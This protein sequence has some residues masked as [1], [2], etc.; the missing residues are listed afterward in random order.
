M[1]KILIVLSLFLVLSCAATEQT[2]TDAPKNTLENV[3]I[4]LGQ[5]LGNLKF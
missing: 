1:K 2:K 5:A 4:A 3:G